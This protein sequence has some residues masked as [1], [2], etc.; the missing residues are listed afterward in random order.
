MEPAVNP[1][2]CVASAGGNKRRQR[3]LTRNDHRYAT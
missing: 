1:N 2:P 3:L